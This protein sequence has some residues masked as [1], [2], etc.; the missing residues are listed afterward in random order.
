M[1]HGFSR[2]T[3]NTGSTILKRKFMNIEVFEKHLKLF[4]KYCTPVSLTDVLSNKS[5]P[6]NPVVLTFD[7]G[8]KNNYKYA[9]PLLKKYKVPATIFITTGFIDQNS[10]IWTDRLEFILDNGSN[11]NIDVTWENKRLELELSTDE[12][13]VKTINNIKNYLKSLAESEKLIFLDQL[14]ETLEIDYNWDRIPAVLSPLTWNEIREMKESGLI[15]IGSHTV[16]HPMLS[17]CTYEQQGRELKF[18][19]QRIVEEL[20]EDCVLFAYPNGKQVDY[21][22]ETIR[23]L[24]ESGY[25][26]AVTTNIG[27][28]DST[29]RDNIQLNRFGTDITLEA[30]GMVVTKMSRLV[31]TI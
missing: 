30:L 26:L 22:Q 24:K 21:N 6:P 12:Q 3:D 1:Y 11:K 14:Q 4:T 20:K 27:Y 23:L 15:S 10:Y 19:R 31:G 18:S 7:D 13:K 2:P 28:V 29:S 5:L 9:F 16:T 17:K 25:L 8:Y